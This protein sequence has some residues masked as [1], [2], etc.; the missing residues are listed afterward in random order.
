[1]NRLLGRVVDASYLG[2]S[3]SY[4]IESGAGERLTVF[5]QNVERT[6]HG[7]LHRPGEQVHLSWSPDHTFAVGKDGASPA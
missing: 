7:S 5:E 4:V 3:T 6:S 1:M 2:A